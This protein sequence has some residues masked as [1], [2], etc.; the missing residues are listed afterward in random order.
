MTFPPIKQ[1]IHQ[2]PA[3]PG[4]IISGILLCGL[5]MQEYLL[6]RFPVIFEEEYL[7]Q[8]FWIAVIHCLLAGYLPSAYLFLLRGTRNT[9]E[10]LKNVLEPVTDPSYVNSAVRFKKRDLIV[11]GLLGVLFAVLLP[12][13]TAT[14]PWDPSTWHPEVVWHRVLEP[15]IGWWAGWFFGAVWITSMRT[16]RLAT[17]IKSVDLL[18]LSPLSPFVKQGLLTTLLTVGMVSIFS[19]LLLD[20]GEW[21]VVA[22][23][24]VGSLLIALVGF[25]LPMR[26]VHRRIH[27]IKEAELKWTREKIHQSEALLHSGSPDSPPGQIADLAAHLQ[28]IE[29]VQEWPF[30]SL[31]I[32]HVLAYLLIP[33]LSWLGGLL[34]ESLLEIIFTI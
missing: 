10:G 1:I 34:I 9:F 24:Y 8:D 21:P 33:L 12:Y 25:W 31:T 7:L 11:W 29:D 16:S 30:E 28:L 2:K 14:S 15:F 20:P 13:Q 4:L 32:V 3:F 22:R 5:L 27:E 17:R 26:G 18:D 19:L 6:G 23:A